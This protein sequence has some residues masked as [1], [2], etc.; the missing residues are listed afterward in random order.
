MQAE[1][2]VV[3]C[4]QYKDIAEVRLTTQHKVFDYQKDV[5]AIERSVV[6]AQRKLMRS[7]DLYDKYLETKL[8][9]VYDYCIYSLFTSLMLEVICMF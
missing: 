6:N 8:K 3:F 7:K 1:Q 9:C 4:D 5:A 2:D